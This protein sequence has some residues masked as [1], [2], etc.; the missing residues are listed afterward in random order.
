MNQGWSFEE[1]IFDTYL[2]FLVMFFLPNV[3]FH[4]SDRQLDAYV[5]SL[6]I[7]L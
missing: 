2:V 1:G 7:T 5:L 6:S 3:F 4:R